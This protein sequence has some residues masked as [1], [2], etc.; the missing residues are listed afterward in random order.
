MDMARPADRH[1]VIYPPRLT[2]A[3]RASVTDVAFR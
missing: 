3:G 2:L 1:V